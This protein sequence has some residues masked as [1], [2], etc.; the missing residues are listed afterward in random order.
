MSDYEK[1][2]LFRS[3]LTGEFFFAPRVR[4]L[5]NTVRLVVGRKYNVTE[6]LQPYLLKKFKL[7]GRTG[8]RV[9]HGEAENRVRPAG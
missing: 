4:V 9:K 6:A 7:N 5:N 2:V 8:R 1:N 3:P